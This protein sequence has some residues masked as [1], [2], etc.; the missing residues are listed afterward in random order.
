MA[1][2]LDYQTAS[3]N[4]AGQLLLNQWRL[5]PINDVDLYLNVPDGTTRFL[6]LLLELGGPNKTIVNYHLP[7]NM[8]L[9]TQAVNAVTVGLGNNTMQEDQTARYLCTAIMTIVDRAVQADPTILPAVNSV[10]AGAAGHPNWNP[11]QEVADGLRVA[12]AVPLP[13]QRQVTD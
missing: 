11:L 12:N 1:A 10:V 9:I 2:I 6:T 3:K 13:A 7:N 5:G 4:P 8:V